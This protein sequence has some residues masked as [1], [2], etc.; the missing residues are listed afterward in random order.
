M[1]DKGPGDGQPKNPMFKSRIFVGNLPTDFL[2]K[3]EVVDRFSKYGPVTGKSPGALI[4]DKS[5]QPS[6][7]YHKERVF[8]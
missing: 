6:D 3:P 7:W 5:E 2:T 4:C 1:G 8:E